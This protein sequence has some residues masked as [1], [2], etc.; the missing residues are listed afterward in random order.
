MGMYDSTLIEQH[1]FHCCGFLIIIKNRINNLSWGG[2]QNEFGFSY[3][4]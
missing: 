3:S 4:I 1:D 2:L